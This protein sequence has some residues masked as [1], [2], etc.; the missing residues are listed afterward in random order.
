[1]KFAG[2]FANFFEMN[3]V[4]IAGIKIHAGFLKQLAGLEDFGL[5]ILNEF[6][7]LAEWQTQAICDVAKDLNENGDH[8]LNV[9]KLPSP[10]C[11]EKAS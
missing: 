8:V 1:M 11:L 10:F 6:S 9:F 7:C 4:Q 5:A 3:T 2:T